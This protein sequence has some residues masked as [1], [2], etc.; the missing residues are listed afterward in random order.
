[1]II[2]AYCLIIIM[3]AKQL[4]YPKIRQ[5]YHRNAFAF[6]PEKVK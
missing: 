4:V 3:I 5:M 1:M 6:L 2:T